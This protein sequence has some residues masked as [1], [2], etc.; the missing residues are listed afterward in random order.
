[1]APRDAGYFFPEWFDS[2]ATWMRHNL[3]FLPHGKGGIP[4]SA[5][6]WKYAEV[7]DPR[8]RT[9]MAKLKAA[10]DYEEH[11]P[12]HD[13]LV[14][15][16]FGH[17]PTASELDGRVG[18]STG[19][20]DVAA[21]LA[22][23][24]NKMI[25]AN[26]LDA[27]KAKQ[28]VSIGQSL[29]KVGM[30]SHAIDT[31]ALKKYDE[32]FG[33]ALK[34]YAKYAAWAGEA[35]TVTG[36]AAKMKTFL[37][38]Y[39]ARYGRLASFFT[40]AVQ[41]GSPTL[42]A[43]A[44]MVA[45]EAWIGEK[46]A[47]AHNMVS[48][49]SG[50]A[51]SEKVG[52]TFGAYEVGDWVT[53]RYEVG[54]HE[55]LNFGLVVAKPANQ[56]VRIAMLSSSEI[57][58]YPLKDVAF[59]SQAAFNK[60]THKDAH[61]DAWVNIVL[62]KERL[63]GTV[64]AP[65]L[66]MLTPGKVT[67]KANTCPLKPV[68]EYARPDDWDD[69]WMRRADPRGRDRDRRRLA[70]TM[71]QGC[72]QKD[73]SD[74]PKDKIVPYEP[75]Q[76]FWYNGAVNE[77]V[78]QAIDA[79]G[80]A[81]AW[82]LRDGSQVRFGDRPGLERQLHY[83]TQAQCKRWGKRGWLPDESMRV[84]Y[85]NERLNRI[86]MRNSIA[87][88]PSMNDSPEYYYLTELESYHTAAHFGNLNSEGVESDVDRLQA[89]VTR[90]HDE[91]LARDARYKEEGEAAQFEKRMDEMR[92]RRPPE[93]DIEEVRDRMRQLVFQI[94]QGTL[95]YGWQEEARRLALELRRRGAQ[96]LTPE[97]QKQIRAALAQLAWKR[98]SLEAEVRL[99]AD[100]IASAEAAVNQN[101]GKQTEVR[102]REML[103]ENHDEFRTKREELAQVEHLNVAGNIHE[104][105]DITG[106]TLG[107]GGGG[108]G[109]GVLIAG[110]AFVA[111]V[112]AFLQT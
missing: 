45:F 14:G 88:S 63:V 95:D 34:P 25:G 94:L 22:N 99:A 26:V 59:V 109:S 97:E 7:D 60:L 69:D 61:L 86:S 54:Q 107:G 18:R 11:R 74:L 65:N 90:W 47:E 105:L 36:I 103:A 57:G 35:A 21:G 75:P 6:P 42:A 110:V 84:V 98:N 16:I 80:F 39:I 50:P 87:R 91:E 62:A 40:T 77:T 92:A 48:T 44:I 82:V 102:L 70:R 31:A 41:A 20:E 13:A 112:L 49:L 17:A 73:A 52:K 67:H 96:E 89:D 27:E 72:E 43:I 38:P 29:L 46:Q 78:G 83:A 55:Q 106:S 19:H 10:H 71:E 3:P 58:P 100:A 4:T 66:L 8:T 32:S 53:A 104:L 24:A 15:H 1:M 93:P 37:V 79:Q 12:E 108:G 68:D 23:A 81:R 28:L 30:K 51:L 64:D 33:A 5:R 76:F 101:I 2:G 56:T 111:F 9:Q 85:W